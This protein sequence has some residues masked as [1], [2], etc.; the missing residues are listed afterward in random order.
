M[1][2]AKFRVVFEGRLSEGADRRE[3]IQN[4]AKAFKLEPSQVELD[5]F[6][7]G[8]VVVK[9]DLSHDQAKQFLAKLLALGGV[10]RIEQ[11]PQAAP[12]TTEPDTH[13]EPP[14]TLTQAD[15]EFPDADVPGLSQSIGPGAVPPS[16]KKKHT[17]KKNK[18]NKAAPKKVVSKKR[19]PKEKKTKPTSQSLFSRLRSIEVGS[20]KSG[21]KDLKEKA[22]QVDLGQT[23]DS[24][25]ERLTEAA[26]DIK[27]TGQQGGVTALVK[28]RHFQAGVGLVLV[29]GV[30]LFVLFGLPAKPPKGFYNST[31]RSVYAGGEEDGT[32][33][34]K[35][36]LKEFVAAIKQTDL[37]WEEFEEDVWIL[38]LRAADKTSGKASSA[39]LLFE[40]MSAAKFR[41]DVVLKSVTLNGRRL[42][43][44]KVFEYATQTGAKGYQRRTPKTLREAVA[45]KDP[46]SLG[47]LLKKKQAPADLNGALFDSVSSGFGNAIDPL[48]QAGADVNALNGKSLN[49]LEVALAQEQFDLLPALANLPMNQAV[50]D[51]ALIQAIA[52]GRVDISKLLIETG[53]DPNVIDATGRPPLLIAIG[54][55]QSELALGLLDTAVDVNFRTAGS[56]PVTALG[57]AMQQKLVPVALRLIEKGAAVSLPFHYGSVLR[58]A[59]DLESVELVEALVEKGAVLDTTASVENSQLIHAVQKRSLPLVEFFLAK[60]VP[61]N[62]RGKNGTNALMEAVR[63]DEIAIAGVLLKGGGDPNQMDEDELSALDIAVGEKKSEMAALLVSAGGIDYIGQ[64]LDQIEGRYPNALGLQEGVVTVHSIVGNTIAFTIKTFQGGGCDL[65]ERRVTLEYEVEERAYLGHLIEGECTLLLKFEPLE[66]DKPWYFEILQDGR[67]DQ[68]C[69]QRAIIAG[70]YFK[71][72]VLKGIQ[73]GQP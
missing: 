38:H 5:L 35:V 54:N 19:T 60:G 13:A 31:L 73:S 44:D 20:L 9:K 14:N 21:I 33:S 43:Y 61:V 24:V 50:R 1:G 2:S 67:C 57:L 72:D 29:L 25:K 71:K 22:K 7:G 26:Q 62:Q 66:I 32:Q 48:V 15:E 51:K 42:S 70:Q 3:V 16:S 8:P 68:I 39:R 30:V 17:Q 40:R 47:K 55:Q 58:R 46:S 6:C 34:L 36:S 4:L 49:L 12:L 53:A 23:R 45:K 63:I 11:Q 10:F 59:I 52:Q 37:R 27:D 64:A 18:K 28:N 41:Q 65:P 69:S 56:Q